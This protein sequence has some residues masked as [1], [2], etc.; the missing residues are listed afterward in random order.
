MEPSP[1]AYKAADVFKDCE[2]C[3]EMVVIP[4]GEF[5]GAREHMDREGPQNTVRIERPFAVGKYEVT[6]AE[7]AA[8]VGETGH[9]AGRCTVVHIGGNGDKTDS[10]G[11]KGWRDPGYEQT[12]RDPVACVSW[13]DANSYLGWLSRK[14]GK[15]YRLPSDS[16]WEYVAWEGTAWYWE[17]RAAYSEDRAAE[18]VN[19]FETPTVTA[20]RLTGWPGF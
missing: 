5:V 1:E 17:E 19:D 11:S 4:P 8:F 3:P 9:E 7:F 6:R 16:E 13:D 14:T 20:V 10:D 18:P 15:T 12:D 2:V